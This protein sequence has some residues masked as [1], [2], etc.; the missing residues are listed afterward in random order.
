MNITT[1][2]IKEDTRDQL[3]LIKIKCRAKNLDEVL[4]TL[5]AN[6]KLKVENAGE[7]NSPDSY[8]GSMEEKLENDARNEA[9]NE[10]R[11][12]EK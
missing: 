8:I 3:M 12:M 6:Y 5:I 10:R 1:I 7:E 11:L 4:K 9:D 2:S